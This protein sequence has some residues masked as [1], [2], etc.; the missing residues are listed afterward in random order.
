MKANGTHISIMD[1]DG[2]LEGTNPDSGMF[3]KYE[4]ALENCLVEA[5]KLIK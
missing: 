2:N 1:I 4:Q 5:L 3:D